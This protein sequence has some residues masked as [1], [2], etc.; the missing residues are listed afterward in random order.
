MEL[1]CTTTMCQTKICCF[2]ISSDQAKCYKNE[3]FS[4]SVRVRPV[5]DSG[6]W[7]KGRPWPKPRCLSGRRCSYSAALNTDKMCHIHVIE[8]EKP[9]ERSTV[10]L[11]RYELNPFHSSTR[12]RWIAFS[13][14]KITRKTNHW[15]Q[16]PRNT[17][18]L[19]ILKSHPTPI[20]KNR[21][22][23]IY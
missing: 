23:Q 14:L 21:Y 10:G 12:I 17:I 2:C 15:F 19:I 7:N 8:N 5:P 1:Y 11:S 18:L 13:P 3:I 4:V 22:K 9:E 16:S 20:I 6:R